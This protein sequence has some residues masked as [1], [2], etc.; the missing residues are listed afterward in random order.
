MKR[1]ILDESGSTLEDVL[2]ALKTQKTDR[3]SDSAVPSKCDI[4]VD[5][6]PCI[7]AKIITTIEM[8]CVKSNLT[9][10]ASAVEIEKAKLQECKQVRLNQIERDR[11]QLSLLFAARSAREKKYR[12]EMHLNT[13]T[14]NALA[15]LS[16]RFIADQELQDILSEPTELMGEFSYGN[17]FAN[18]I[19]QVDKENA[20]DTKRRS[21][22]SMKETYYWPIIKG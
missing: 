12:E 17:E 18:L 20:Y 14:D 4:L 10:L 16:M 15:R 19:R 11:E 22:A 2:E 5:S 13:D 6:E 7:F 3:T 21:R 1:A 8:H 9:N